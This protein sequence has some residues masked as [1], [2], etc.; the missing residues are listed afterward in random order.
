MDA[1]YIHIC[2][3]APA[4]LALSFFC[5]P[6]LFRSLLP[7]ALLQSNCFVTAT[8]IH[9]AVAVCVWFLFVESCDLSC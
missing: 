3:C 1:T 5:L 8:S 9:V 2:M 7:S 6:T 4:V